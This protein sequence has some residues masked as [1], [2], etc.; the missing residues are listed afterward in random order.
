[1]DYIA[2]YEYKETLNEILSQSHEGIV[3]SESGKNN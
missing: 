2:T 3:R 1:M